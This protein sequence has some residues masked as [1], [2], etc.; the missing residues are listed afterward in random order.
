MTFENP[1]EQ[2][3]DPSNDRT[4]GNVPAGVRKIPAKG[5]SYTRPLLSRSVTQLGIKRHYLPLGVVL[6]VSF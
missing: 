6:V 5:N 2:N 3:P 1:W 4:I